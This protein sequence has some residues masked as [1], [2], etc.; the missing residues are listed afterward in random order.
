MLEFEEYKVKLNN[1]KP[2]LDDLGNALKLADAKA[3]I[4]ELEKQTEKD[5]FWDD[6]ETSQRVL[7]RTKNLKAK[8]EMFKKLQDSFD[9]LY[10]ICVMALEENDDSMETF[11]EAISTV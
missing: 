10:A 3:E 7:K 9:D 11:P 2:T 1:L 4:A 8:C 5:G 6:L